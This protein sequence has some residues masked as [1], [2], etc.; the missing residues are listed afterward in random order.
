M[1]PP[2][3]IDTMGLSQE[4][5]LTRESVDDLKES[6]VRVV[7][8]VVESSW[9]EEAKKALKSTRS[10]YLNSIIVGEEGRFT[11]IITLVGELPNMLESGADPFDMKKGFEKSDKRVITRNS[12]GVLGWY[13][14][15]PFTWA[16]PGS[17]GDSRKF[18]G[19]L[20]KDVSKALKARQSERGQESVL[21]LKSIPDEFKVPKTR[22]PVKL[23]DSTLMPEYQ[24]KHSVYEGLQ[25]KQKGGPVMSFRR[26]SGNSD[27]SSWVHTGITAYNLAEKALSSSDIPKVVGD[28][29]DSHLDSMLG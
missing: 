25:Q 27:D 10:Q 1:L 9:R 8:K 13:L 4:F 5:D 23:A 19:V 18:T 15:I 2:I 26:V 22:S 28:V 20:P 14:T 21:D 6:I 24:N 16:Q 29:I 17:I 7:T 11:N 12:K 3:I